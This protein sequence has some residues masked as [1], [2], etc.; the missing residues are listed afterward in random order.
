MSS[1]AIIDYHAPFHQDLTVQYSQTPVRGHHWDQI[2]FSTKEKC[3]L[4]GS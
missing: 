1:Q 2:Q 4:M 3:L